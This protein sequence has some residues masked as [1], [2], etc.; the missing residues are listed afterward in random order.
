[1]IVQATVYEMQ[2]IFDKR[3]LKHSHPSI[4]IYDDSDIRTVTKF[5][6]HPAGNGTLETIK[7]SDFDAEKNAWM[8]KPSKSILFLEYPQV[9]EKAK[10]LFALIEGA[11]LKLDE[12]IS[13]YKQQ[14]YYARKT[15]Q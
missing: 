1:M 4:D 8:G 12:N 10:E 9:K 14:Y 13:N 3:S 7:L 6:V 5:R 15:E 2:N 11:K